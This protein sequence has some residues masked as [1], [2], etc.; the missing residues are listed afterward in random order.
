M[1]GVLSVQIKYDCTFQIP[2]HNK[3][4]AEQGLRHF[5]SLLLNKTFLLTLIRTLEQQKKFTM[6]DRVEVASLVSVALQ[7]YMDYHTE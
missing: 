7:P 6:R 2:T 3:D 1:L 5:S 4:M